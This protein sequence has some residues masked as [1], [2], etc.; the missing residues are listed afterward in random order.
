MVGKRNLCLQM[1]I[2]RVALLVSLKADTDTVKE[3]LT[4]FGRPH[5]DLKVF[6]VANKAAVGTLKLFDRPINVVFVLDLEQSVG[7]V[8]VVEWVKD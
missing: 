7:R 2:L 6:Q 4:W 3:S 1:D 8:S 5:V